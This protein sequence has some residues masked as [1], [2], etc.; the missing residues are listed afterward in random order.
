M[1]QRP[2]AR[3]RIVLPKRPSARSRI[4]LPQASICEVADS[5][6]GLTLFDCQIHADA[7]TRNLRVGLEGFFVLLVTSFSFSLFCFFVESFS[8]F[9]W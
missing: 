8:L 3:S 6:C 2:S 5:A 7:E 4:V 1:L 9:C